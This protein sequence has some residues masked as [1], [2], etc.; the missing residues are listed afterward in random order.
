MGDNADMAFDEGFEGYVE[1]QIDYYE[2]ADPNPYEADHDDETRPDTDEPEEFEYRRV[3]TQTSRAWLLE[4]SGGA[5]RWF[6]KSMC[7]LDGDK[8]LV[9]TWLRLKM[10]RDER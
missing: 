1:R 6:P 4:M 8:V 7:S 10:M 2:D 9:P 5:N 3:V